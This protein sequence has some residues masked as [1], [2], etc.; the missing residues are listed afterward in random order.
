MKLFLLVSFLFIFTSHVY[1]QSDCPRGMVN[2]R[3]PGLCGQYIDNNQN[4]ICDKSEIVPTSL[5]KT[6]QD[7][8]HFGS[9]SLVLIA[10]YAFSWFSAHKKWWSMVTHRQ[11]WN[12]L[13]GLH[14]LATALLGIILVIRLTY[15]ITTKPP[16]NLLFWHVE[17]GII[18]SVI[19]IFHIAWHWPYIKLIFSKPKK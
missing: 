6:T 4:L 19:A 10:I 12:V 18:F 16:I 8:Y 14:F 5:P 2:D 13:L 15:G 7:S 17:T 3:Y 9:I 1:A 11:V